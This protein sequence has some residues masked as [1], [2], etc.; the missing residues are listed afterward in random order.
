MVHQ[1]QILCLYA[2]M[3]IYIELQTKH[4][5]ETLIY[6]IYSMLRQVMQE[7]G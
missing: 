2:Y 7:I 3:Y 4:M 6:I 5:I 1:K